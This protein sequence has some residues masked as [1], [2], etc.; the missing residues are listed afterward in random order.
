MYEKVLKRV[1]RA[2]NENNKLRK[3]E[4]MSL[5]IQ[6]I[7]SYHEQKICHICKKELS[8]NDNDKARDHS[9]YTRKYK[10][11]AHNACN[12]NYKAPKEIP[13]VFRNGSIC[14][15]LHNQSASKRL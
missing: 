11:V 14:D 7:K 6:E 12:L 8:T 10:G 4:M 3:K 9:Q 1:N 15:S 2:R 13:V 5:T